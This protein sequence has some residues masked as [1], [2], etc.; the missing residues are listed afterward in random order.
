[1]ILNALT[2]VHVV[3]SLIGIG[4]GVCR[5]LRV[6]KSENARSM[7]A[8]LP[9]DDGGD[10]PDGLPVPLFTASRLL[11]SSASSLLSP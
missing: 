8:G 11:R 1:M 3:L 4:S 5:N 10:K 7:D 2:V 6:A 9:R